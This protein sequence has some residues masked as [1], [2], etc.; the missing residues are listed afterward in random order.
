MSTAATSLPATDSVP[1]N[2]GPPSLR[3]RA[4]RGAAWTL[5]GYGAGQVLRFVTN[6][7]LA[8][9]LAPE[10]FGLMA[11]VNA[12]LQGLQ[13]FSDIGIG[14]ALIQSPRGE[15]RAFQNT[16]FTIQAGRGVLLGG[17]AALLAA[18]VAWFYNE[19]Q[20]A[21]LLPAVGL[22]AVIS[23]FNAPALFVLNRRL[24]LGRLMLLDLA[25]QAASL[26]VTVALALR[27]PNVWAL[28]IG[29]LVSTL[30]RVLSTHFLLAPPTARFRW[31]R[32]AARELFHFGRWIFISTLLTFVVMQG[33]RLIFGKLV[34]LDV[35]GVYSIAVALAALPREA[36]GRLGS[37]VVFPSYSAVV[38]DPARLQSAFQK[39]RRPMGAAAALCAAFLLATGPTMVRVLY[40]ARYSNAGWMM[41]WLALGVLL[42]VLELMN[43]TVLLAAGNSRAVALGNGV[44]LVGMCVLLPVGWWLG[45]FAGTLAALLVTDAAKYVCS[46]WCVRRMNLPVLRVDALLFAMALVLGGAGAW[47]GAYLCR[48]NW[49]ADLVSW[50]LNGVG[51]GAWL[52]AKNHGLWSVSVLHTALLGAL[53][54]AVAAVL[55]G[56]G[57]RWLVASNVNRT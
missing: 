19:P 25:T 38:R 47:L 8:R 23:G 34:P 3:K 13:M 5:V 20:L 35:L 46:A 29:A 9:L 16:A 6:V 14:P 41:Q 37:S 50:A 36:L 49:G 15:E 48:I 56:L 39:A 21:W 12:I 10:L 11:I 45:E 26:V 24:A 42:Q 55:A 1:A 51:G 40:D 52:A 33:D 28:V 44:K 22:T 17:V 2:A 57:R 30:L 43:G 31:D 54:L 7:I 18:P 27:W 53:A 4:I 32:T